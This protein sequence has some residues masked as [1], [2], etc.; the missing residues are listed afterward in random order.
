MFDM[1]GT[2]VNS[3]TIIVNT[4]NHVR[5]STGLD[6]MGHDYLLS[7]IN[8]PSI[9]PAK[10]FYGTDCF[11]PMH[12]KLFEDYYDKHCLDTIFLYEG[13]EELLAKLYEKNFTL[14]IATN[15]SNIFARKAVEHLNIDKYIKYVVGFDDVKES[16]PH[17]E[18]LLKTMNELSFSS[19]QSQLVGDS[20]KDLMAAQNAD[21]KC[22]LVNWGFSDHQNDGH[23]CT[24]KLFETIV[25]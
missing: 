13:I 4:I 25:S 2:L 15:A 10:F 17:P 22:H 24:K 23:N 12:T 14:T 9:D 3:G 5:T 7:N 8:D 16:K 19:Q 6:P 1:D 20:N 18:M 11:T 21:I